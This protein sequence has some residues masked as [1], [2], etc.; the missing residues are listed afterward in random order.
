MT[1][2]T[3]TKQYVRAELDMEPPTATAQGKR[4]D[5]RGKKP[6]FYRS[7][8][9]EAVRSEY[10]LRL[11]KH[12]PEKPME[13]PLSLHVTFAF[14]PRKSDAKVAHRERWKDTQP[15]TD[16][17]LKELK[18]VLAELQFFTND[19]QIAHEV[20]QKTWAPKPYI[21]VTLR[22]IDPFCDGDVAPLFQSRMEAWGC[23]CG[24]TNRAVDTECHHCGKGGK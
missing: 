6:R 16:N 12:R 4:V 18:D 7:T 24:S 3:K 2:T 14:P 13:G 17:M 5:T 23:G 10:M 1:K 9:V 8:A 21:M 20:T 15:D 11:K 22:E 19:G